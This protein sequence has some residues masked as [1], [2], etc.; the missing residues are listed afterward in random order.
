MLLFALIRVSRGL[1][2]EQ[3]DQ[4]VFDKNIVQQGLE[5]VP[6]VFPS[7][8]AITHFCVTHICVM[9]RRSAK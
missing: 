5:T 2:L 8:C 9:K 7:L 3:S 4:V 6:P 1:F